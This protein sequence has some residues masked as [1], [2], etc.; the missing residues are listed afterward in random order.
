M[1]NCSNFENSHITRRVANRNKSNQSMTMI[2][3]CGT[4]G[5]RNALNAYRFRVTIPHNRNGRS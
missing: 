1:K 2:K 3:Y 5:I 4:K